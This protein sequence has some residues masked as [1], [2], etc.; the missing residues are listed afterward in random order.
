VI[1]ALVAAALFAGPSPTDA[2]P[3]VV[4]E[5]RISRGW[6]RHWADIAAREEPRP[7]DRWRREAASYLIGGHWIRGEAAERGVA[8]PRDEVTRALRKAFPRTREQ[9][10][11]LRE[12]GM[13]VSDLRFSVK[14]ELLSDK[15]RALVTAGIED[16]EAQQDA[17]QGFIAAYYGKWTERTACRRPWTSSECGTTS[18]GRTRPAP[19]RGRR[20]SSWGGGDGGD[21][22]P[23]TTPFRPIAPAS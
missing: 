18:P 1:A 10:R 4:G 22:I 16:P 15:L 3:V 5:Q 14:T 6:L 7:R 20:T 9:R 2:H 23:S 13:T 8:A 11:F 12:S 17:L 19:S 21:W